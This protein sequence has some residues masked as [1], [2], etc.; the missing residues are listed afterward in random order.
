MQDVE[1][2]TSE[3]G[4]RMKLVVALLIVAIAASVIA[5]LYYGQ[6]MIV[7]SVI[8]L[9]LETAASVLDEAGIGVDTKGMDGVVVAQDPIAGEQWFRNNDFIITYS[10]DSGTRTTGG[11]DPAG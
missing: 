3:L 2:Q 9:P 10:N 5:L 6:P 11:P 1:P 7:P 8:G 4:A